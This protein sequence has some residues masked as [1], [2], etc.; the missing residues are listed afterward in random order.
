MSFLQVLASEVVVYKNWPP[1]TESF[2]VKLQ[3]YNTLSQYLSENFEKIFRM[4]V[5]HKW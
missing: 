3:Y 2:L 5:L 4:A 1:V